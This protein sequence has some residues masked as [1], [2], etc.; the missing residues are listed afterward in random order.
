M[1]TQL[2]FLSSRVTES[3]YQYPRWNS[4][5]NQAWLGMH[6]AYTNTCMYV[7]TVTVGLRW[8]DVV[9]ISVMSP[10]QAISLHTLTVYIDHSGISPH[11]FNRYDSMLMKATLILE[12]TW[13]RAIWKVLPLLR[14][15][16][17]NHAVLGRYMTAGYMEGTTLVEDSQWK[18]CCFSMLL[19]AL[20][21]S[22]LLDSMFIDRSKL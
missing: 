19:V 5:I 14:T 3:L 15:L 20:G 22:Q 2:L 12:G 8:C 1:R 17:E 11:V 18:P 21:C 7:R 9:Y 4:T 6:S 13:Q 10:T 16:N